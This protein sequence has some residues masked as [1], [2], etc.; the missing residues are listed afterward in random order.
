MSATAV[1]SIAAFVL[2]RRGYDVTAGLIKV[3]LAMAAAV[4]VGI[5]VL[6]I[7]PT[8]YESWWLD[9]G[10]G[11]AIPVPL[12]IIG[13]PF[14]LAILIDLIVGRGGIRKWLVIIIGGVLL[15]Y[16]AELAYPLAVI[17]IGLLLLGAPT[18][19]AVLRFRGHQALAAP[20]GTGA[21]SEKPQS[22]DE[23][24]GEFEAPKKE[25]QGDGKGAD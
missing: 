7:L 6:S 11:F 20:T 25:E 4:W 18:I 16:A 22:E 5:A 15:G 13:I 21:K 24:L 17:P 8:F 19:S 9:F 2:Y 10:G 12:A 1:L 3:E 14:F 23:F